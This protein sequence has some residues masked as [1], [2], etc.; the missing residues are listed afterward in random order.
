MR[1]S[2][3]KRSL[4]L[5]ALSLL[6]AVLLVEAFGMFHLLSYRTAVY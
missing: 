5:A 6:V 4:L 2:T 1:N 3:L